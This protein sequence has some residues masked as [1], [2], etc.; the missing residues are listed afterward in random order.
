M[1]LFPLLLPVLFPDGGL[2]LLLMSP[3]RAGGESKSSESK[4]KG[5]GT[6]RRRGASCSLFTTIRQRRVG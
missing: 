4:G 1:L 2:S 6:K 3:V 5:K